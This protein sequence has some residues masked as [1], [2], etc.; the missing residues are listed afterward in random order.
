MVFSLRLTCCGN[1][2]SFFAAWGSAALFV[3]VSYFS[4]TVDEVVVTWAAG[5]G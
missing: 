4:L 3:G 1:S 5:R 2:A